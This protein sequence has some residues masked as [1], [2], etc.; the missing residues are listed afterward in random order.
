MLSEARIIF[1][2]TTETTVSRY[3][4]FEGTH[5]RFNV[6]INAAGAKKIRKRQED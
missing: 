6:A 4:D 1:H 3:L 5:Y 2:D